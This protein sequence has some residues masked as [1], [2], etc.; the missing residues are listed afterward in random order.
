MP[1]PFANLLDWIGR[2]LTRGVIT[3]IRE[4]RRVGDEDEPALWIV[5]TAENPQG[6]NAFITEFDVETVAPFAAKAVG[7][8][9][10]HHPA[11]VT[12]GHLAFNVPGHGVSEPPAIIASFDQRLPY[13]SA[14]KGRIAASG[15]AGFR[16]RWQE[17][18][19]EAIAEGSTE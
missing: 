7:Y 5:A 3:H 1:N 13:S 14:C 4:A 8:E 18:E 10:R 16:K 17:F 11:N 6:E 19:C 15:R 12:I 2:R 9:Y